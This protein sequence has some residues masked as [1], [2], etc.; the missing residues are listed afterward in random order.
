MIRIGVT[1]YWFDF[2]NEVKSSWDVG[3][4]RLALA[5]V[6]M[7]RQSLTTIELHQQ[8]TIA[9]IANHRAS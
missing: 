9:M 4:Q 1:Q 5:H 2:L 8:A 6:A 7:E 3:S